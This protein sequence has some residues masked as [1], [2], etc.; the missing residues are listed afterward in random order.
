VSVLDIITP[1]SDPERFTPEETLFF[2][3]GRCGWV[4]EYG[5]GRGIRHCGQQSEPGASF[6]N[7]AEHNAELLEDHWPDGTPRR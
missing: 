4:V 3:Q 6:G 2:R 7:C 5:N 1:D